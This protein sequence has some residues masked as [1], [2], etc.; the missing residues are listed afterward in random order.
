MN[1][2]ESDNPEPVERE[3]ILNMDNYLDAGTRRKSRRMMNEESV[4]RI[5]ETNRSRVQD[6]T[7]R[8]LMEEEERLIFKEVLRRIQ[9]RKDMKLRGEFFDLEKFTSHGSG[10][11]TGKNR[12]ECD[13]LTPTDKSAKML[14]HMNDSKEH[15]TSKELKLM[16]VTNRS[17]ATSMT[18]YINFDNEKK[19]RDEREKKSKDW[20]ERR[21]IERKNSKLEKELQAKILMNNSRKSVDSTMFFGEIKGEGS[22]GR[23]ERIREG[24]EMHIKPDRRNTISGDMVA[25]QK[26]V[27][28]ANDRKIRE[29]NVSKLMQEYEKNI[30][31]EIDIKLALEREKKT[32]STRDINGL[33]SNTKKL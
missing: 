33:I 14:N 24:I 29:K 8:Q 27:I 19:S 1:L 16:T 22:E 5:K 10:T 23:V 28:A 15:I 32:R 18:T 12:A 6:E 4:R 9:K 21:L 25:N 11:T 20:S 2:I 3:I 31:V 13:D 30:K 26:S 7:E 17:G